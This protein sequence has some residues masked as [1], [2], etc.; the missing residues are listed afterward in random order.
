MRQIIIYSSSKPR[1]SKN[2]STELAA[3]NTI[4]KY[5]PIR[6]EPG[7]STRLELYGYDGGL[8][9]VSRNI[10]S[11]RVL[12]K[13]LKTC[14]AKIDK[15]PMG[16]LEAQL[17]NTNPTNK[18]T[19]KTLK[20]GT[21]K[22]LLR[23]CNL[24]DIPETAH[25]FADSTHHTCCMLGSKAREYADSSGNPIGT[26]SIRVQSQMKTKKQKKITDKRT[27]KQ[28]LAPWCTCTGSKVCTYYTD[29]FGKEDGTHIKFIGTLSSKDANAKNEEA[30]I[31]KLRL[32]SHQTPGVIT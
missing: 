22:S 8:K 17:R 3:R 19:L 30:A 20:G 4:I 16:S 12:I 13:S 23:K 1:I 7:S 10:S 11:A 28:N 29:K 24:P 2:L 6:L 18:K 5:V 15:M 31:N 26:L 27:N 14:I 25:C 21:R 9:Y 32:Q